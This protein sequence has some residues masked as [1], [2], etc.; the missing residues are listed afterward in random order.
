MVSLAIGWDLYE[1]TGD[2]WA[3]GLVGLAEVVPV[4]LFL[5]PAGVASDRISRRNVTI[6]ATLLAMLAVAGLAAATWARTPLWLTYALLS[7]LGTS[8]A[9]GQPAAASFVPE[10]MAPEERARLNAWIAAS[11]EAAAIGGPA[12]AG[13]L[14]GAT[15]GAS[16]PLLAACLGQALFVASL[17]TLPSRPPHAGDDAPHH[18]SDL[19]A[20]IRFIRRTPVFLAAITLDLLAVLLAGSI[21]LLPVY[22]KDIL[23][24]GPVGLGWL[25]TAPSLGALGMSLVATRLR[26]WQRPGRVLL[27]AVAGFGLATIG[28]GLSTN[29]WLSLG[30]LFFTSLF[31]MISVI[32]RITLEQNI[33]PDPLRGRVSAINFLFVGLSN[34][35]GAFE[36]GAVA[37]LI[38]PVATVVGGGAAAVLAVVA[39]ARIWPELVQVGPLHTVRPPGD[40][41]NFP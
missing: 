12:I 25:R 3:L 19:L 5:I 11:Y 40:A 2:P 29:I 14:I 32:I 34:E 7:L 28:F 39:V 22:A 41:G 33:T 38:G 15:G 35:L 4:V 20:G 6:A 17:L 10:L 24:V 1:R 8:R 13:L 30:C 36:S 37:A 27:W 18:A 9:F 16:V 31:D 23:H 26:P 21:A